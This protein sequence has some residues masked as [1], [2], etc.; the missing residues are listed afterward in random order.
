MF[1]FIVPAVVVGAAMIAAS[2]SNKKEP[3]RN[4]KRDVQNIHNKDRRKR[5]L[6]EIENFKFSEKERLMKKHDI[7]HD[8]LLFTSK[9]H[10]S[11]IPK[12]LIYKNQKRIEKLQQEITYLDEVLIQIKN[13]ER[14]HEEFK[15]NK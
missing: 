6:L 12:K 9:F 11:Y 2:S 13:M 4:S 10:V 14:Q 5:Y 1:W 15:N 3:S 7:C 8:C